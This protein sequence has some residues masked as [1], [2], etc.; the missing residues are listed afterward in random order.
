MHG[1]NLGIDDKDTPGP[2][3]TG[4][5]ERR[6]R[7]TE[8]RESPTQQYCVYNKTRESFLALRVS[9]ADTHLARLRGLLGAGRLNSDEGIWV[10]PSQGIHSM[11]LRFAIDLIYLDASDRVIETI[12]SFGTFRIGPL[13]MKCESVLELPTRTIFHSQ[14]QVG[15]QLLICHPEQIEQ[16]LQEDEI[17]HVKEAAAQKRA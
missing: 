8:I 16:Y 7:V 6:I 2:V 14:T 9:R 10:T 1:R 17:Q 5:S 12:E 3:F 15:D 4:P 11:G 13:R